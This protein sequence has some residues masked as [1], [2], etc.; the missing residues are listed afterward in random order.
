[1]YYWAP[2]FGYYS[3]GKFQNQPRD[4]ECD[5][6]LPQSIQRDRIV[7]ALCDGSSLTVSH[8]ISPELW[9][10]LLTPDGRELARI[11]DD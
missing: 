8:R 1:M 9:H 7:V 6:A 10:H 3:V 5:P 2:M 11:P 4:V